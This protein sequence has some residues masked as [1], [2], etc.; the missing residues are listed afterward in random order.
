M[1]FPC[2]HG[3]ASTHI[4]SLAHTFFRNKMWNGYDSSALVT[5]A[6]GAEKNSV[7]P[8]IRLVRC[9]PSTTACR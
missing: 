6:K 2:L 8:M 7:M 3:A 5:M 9:I 4:D 1:A